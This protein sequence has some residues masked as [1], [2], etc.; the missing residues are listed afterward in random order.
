MDKF[1]NIKKYEIITK[2]QNN[3][4]IDEELFIEFI[5]S[6]IVKYKYRKKLLILDYFPAHCTENVKK[7]LIHHNIDFIFI[8]KNM[9]FVLRPLDRTINNPF[10]NI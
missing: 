2:T 10:K 4:W 5:N 9:T 3:S 1:I 8:P 6:V 7:Q